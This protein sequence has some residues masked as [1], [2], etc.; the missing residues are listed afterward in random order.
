MDHDR[1][2]RLVRQHA[3]TSALFG[4][5]F[6]PLGKAPEG[7]VVEQD[8]GRKGIFGNPFRPA[9]GEERQGKTLEPY[10]AWLFAAI[11]G[12]PWAIAQYKDATGIDLPKD[13]A[14][15]VQALHGLQFWCPGCKE[16]TE[17]EGVCHG[18][19]LRKAVNWLNT[20]EGAK[21]VH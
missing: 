6:V 12:Q 4:V 14:A 13:F 7:I 11:Q 3:E 17:A 16:K 5:D 18:S 19:V 10:R 9:A 1:L 15:R 8:I 21:H 2:R 20:P